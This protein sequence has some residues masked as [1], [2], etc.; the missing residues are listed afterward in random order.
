MHSYARQNC[1]KRL[2]LYTFIFWLITA[3][4]INLSSQVQLF[5]IKLNALQQV[6][7][8]LRDNV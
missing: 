3:I 8:P 5:C 2:A 4:N 7:K 1:R 6:E